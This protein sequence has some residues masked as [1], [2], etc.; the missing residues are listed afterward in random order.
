MLI[1]YIYNIGILCYIG[2]ILLVYGELLEVMPSS[3]IPGTTT[4]RRNGPLGASFHC[5]FSMLGGDQLVAIK[6]RAGQEAGATD[7][8]RQV[9]YS[10]SGL[11]FRIEDAGILLGVERICCF[12]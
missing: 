7:L 8:A 11:Y 12:S 3:P 2:Y 1:I 9:L 10:G 4:R 6:V 5:V